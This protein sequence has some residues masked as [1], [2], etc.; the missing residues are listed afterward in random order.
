MSTNNNPLEDLDRVRQRM[1]D[2]T[3]SLMVEAVRQ[4]MSIQTMSEDEEINQACR[5][6]SICMETARLVRFDTP[7]RHYGTCKSWL[8]GWDDCIY[9][10]ARAFKRED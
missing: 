9:S 3:N 10:Y 2:Y 5:M 7:Y 1:I 6:S 8:D 4:V